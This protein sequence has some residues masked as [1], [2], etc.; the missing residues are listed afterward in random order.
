MTWPV[1]SPTA[2]AIERR[3]DPAAPEVDVDDV[4]DGMIRAWP[5]AVARGRSTESS[6]RTMQR[7]HRCGLAAI[8]GRHVIRPT[9]EAG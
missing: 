7:A 2:K 8:A 4:E 3:G 5:G 9:P 1:V 6:A